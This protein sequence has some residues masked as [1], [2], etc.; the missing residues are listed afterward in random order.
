MAELQWRVVYAPVCRARQNAWWRE[1]GSRQVAAVLGG[2]GWRLAIMAAQHLLHAN[3]IGLVIC[4]PAL[5]L[6]QEEHW[7]TL[8]RGPACKPR[9]SAWAASDSPP[10][11]SAA[12]QQPD[13]SA[14]AVGVQTQDAARCSGGATAIELLLQEEERRRELRS[15]PA[16]RGK[17]AEAVAGAA[18]SRPARSSRSSR[19]RRRQMIGRMLTIAPSLPL[20]PAA[21]SAAVLEG[22]LLSGAMWCRQRQGRTISNSPPAWQTPSPPTATL[23]GRQFP[24]PANSSGLP[25]PQAAA[26]RGD[27]GGM[28]R[29]R[30]RHHR[31]GQQQQP[32]CCLQLLTALPPQPQTGMRLPPGTIRSCRPGGRRSQL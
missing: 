29:C 32:W 10:G 26:S 12:A 24:R 6:L 22:K 11:A 2:H 16:L 18:Q 31:R 15:Q 19:R 9:S 25:L 13:A 8:L 30:R 17:P 21:P 27:R 20:A 23:A 1:A 28:H 14:S 7:Q 4:M 5:A 3:G